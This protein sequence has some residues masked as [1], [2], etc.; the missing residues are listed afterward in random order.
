MSETRFVIQTDSTVTMSVGSGI[1]PT[2]E[3]ATGSQTI[4][5]LDRNTVRSDEGYVSY[6]IN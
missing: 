5:I 3:K 4:D 6:R 1:P 2:T